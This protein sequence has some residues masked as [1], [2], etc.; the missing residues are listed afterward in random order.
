MARCV[1][2]TGLE[3]SNLTF[4][5]QDF[6]GHAIAWDKTLICMLT[7]NPYMIYTVTDIRVSIR[8]LRSKLQFVTVP[9]IL[10]IKN[11]TWKTLSRK[12]DFDF[13]DL[14]HLIMKNVVSKVTPNLVKIFSLCNHSQSTQMSMQGS[15]GTKHFQK[16]CMDIFLLATYL[17]LITSSQEL[18]LH[19]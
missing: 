16:N 10:T 6:F 4:N 1:V 11:Q 3:I 15:L 8:F 17:I 2:L 9:E 18:P 13:Q 5:I 14:K 12:R 19:K 7:D